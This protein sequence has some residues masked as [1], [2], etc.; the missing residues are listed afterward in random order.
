MSWGWKCHHWTD[1]ALKAF[2]DNDM[3]AKVYG[4]APGST[5]PM[6]MALSSGAGIKERLLRELASP[7]GPTMCATIWCCRRTASTLCLRRGRLA[8]AEAVTYFHDWYAEGLMDVEMF[9]QDTNQ[10]LAKGAQSLWG[11]SRTIWYIEEL[12][13]DYSKD[14][15]FLLPVLDGPDGT[16]NVTVRTGGGTAFT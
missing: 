10:L 4:N 3:S 7:T 13:G 1:A 5:I 16:H 8:T 12:M 6:S 9:S 15:V 11:V 2:K 14:Y